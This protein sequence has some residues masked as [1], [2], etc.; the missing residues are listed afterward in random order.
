MDIETVFLNDGYDDAFNA[1]RL[2][3]SHLDISR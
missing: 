3:V 2:I 1:D